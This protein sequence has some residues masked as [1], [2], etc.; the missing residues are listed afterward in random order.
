MS[1]VLQ[2]PAAGAD[3]AQVDGHAP[4]QD[5]LLTPAALAFLAGLHRRF[6]PDRQARLAARRQRQA[7]FDA[8]GLP[9]FRTDTAAI[10][11]G[12]WRVAPLPPALLDRRV[13]ITGPT[14]PKVVIN[15]LNSG[16]RVYMADFEDSTAPTWANLVTGQ[17]AL[18]KAVAGTL[19]WMSPEGRHYVLRPFAEQ[20]VLMVRPR[21]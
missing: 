20:A 1:A 8:G 9:D 6:E 2:P 3:E 10:R 18:R 21:G 17:R 7:F 13:E 5:A 15:A 16:A 4:G 14:D 19:D 11:A 12:D